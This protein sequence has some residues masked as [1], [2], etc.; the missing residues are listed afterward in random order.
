MKDNA[1]VVVALEKGNGNVVVIM[2]EKDNGTVTV[3]EEERQ[4]KFGGFDR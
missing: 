2:V 1:I 3:V 4:W